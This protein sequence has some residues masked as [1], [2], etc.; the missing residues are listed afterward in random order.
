MSKKGWFEDGMFIQPKFMKF[1]PG[2]G[3]RARDPLPHR[4]KSQSGVESLWVLQR[5]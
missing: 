2:I 4:E 5:E 3:I 1:L